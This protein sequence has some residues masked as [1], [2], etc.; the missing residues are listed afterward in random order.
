MSANT[1]KQISPSATETPP[2]INEVLTREPSG[3]PTFVQTPAEPAETHSPALAPLI[4]D[5]APTPLHCSLNGHEQVA[6]AEPDD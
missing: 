2:A 1:T 6:L 5:L 4:Q 3:S